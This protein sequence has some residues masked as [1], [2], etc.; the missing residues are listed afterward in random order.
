MK[1]FLPRSWPY[2]GLFLCCLQMAALPLNAQV[3]TGATVQKIEIRHVGPPPPAT[4]SS[5][6]YP[7]KIGKCNRTG[8]TTTCGRLFDRLF[9]NIRV[10]GERTPG[11]VNLIYVVQANHLT[12]IRFEGNKKSNKKLL[13]KHVEDRYEPL[14]TNGSSSMIARNPEDLPKGRISK[15]RSQG[16]SQ[17]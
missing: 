6:Q 2:W 11:G 10:A 9:Y 4:S 12:D 7:V 15:D 13:R 14:S 3:L 16:R 8:V 17:R 1:F 5:G